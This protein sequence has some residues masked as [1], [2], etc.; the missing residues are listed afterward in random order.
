MPNDHNVP[1][2]EGLELGKT[3]LAREAESAFLTTGI[4]KTPYD[5][6]REILNSTQK[7]LAFL[8]ANQSGKTH[9]GVIKM[10]WDATGLYPEWYHGRRTTRGIDAWI[11]GKTAENTRDTAQKKLFGSNIDK[12]GWT[13]KPGQEALIGQKYILAKPTRKPVPGAFDTVL[14]KHVP[15]DTTSRLMFKSH[16][17]DT[18]ALASWS[19]DRVLVDE[20]CPKEV[21]DELIARVSVSDG[22]IFITLC[23]LDGLTPLVKWIMEMAERHPSLLKLCY[24]TY[25][26]AQ[27]LDPTVKAANR[28]L[29]SSNPAMMAARTEGRA[30]SNHGLIFPFAIADITYDPTQI[31]IP[32][33]WPRL[34]GLDVGFRHPTAAVA[35]ALDLASDTAYVYAS[36]ERA[37]MPYGYHHGQLLNWG[38]NMTFMIDPAS[39]QVSQA[40]GKTI[41]QGLWSLTH[42]QPDID[43][44]GGY[45]AIEETKRKYIKANNSFAE[46]QD[47]MWHRFGSRRLLISRVLKSL[48]DQYGSYAWNTDGNGPKRETPALRYDII[49]SLRY[50]TLGLAQYAHRLNAI[51]PWQE[52]EEWEDVPQVKEWKKYRAGEGGQG[53]VLR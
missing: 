25:D 11:M 14:V 7:I 28:A 18:V 29:W 49:T 45:M 26:D 34:G 19:G 23:P 3:I 51:P 16:Q 8:G 24:L 20:E 33:H 41:L 27:H 42:G 46:S 6:Q 53:Q 2:L 44:E 30:V 9:T 50:C 5:P 10:A 35:T 17:M 43:G 48:L 13:D 37:E 4:A 47:A 38:Q 1:A 15:S 21:L 39:D 40:D 52:V 22:Q 31:I 12:P 36:Y 32:D